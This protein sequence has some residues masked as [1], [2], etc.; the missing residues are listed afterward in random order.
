[1]NSFRLL[2]MSFYIL[3]NFLEHL[4][5]SKDLRKFKKRIKCLLSITISFMSQNESNL[6]L[7]AKN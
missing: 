6:I 7:R 2:K 4:L 3:I 5:M 1:L